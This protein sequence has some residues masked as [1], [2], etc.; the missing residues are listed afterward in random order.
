MAG[1]KV[2]QAGSADQM[3]LSRSAPP[4]GWTR[5]IASTS[6]SLGGQRLRACAGA[7]PS[8][9]ASRHSSSGSTARKLPN[10]ALAVVTL[11]YWH[12]SDSAAVAWRKDC[13]YPEVS[14]V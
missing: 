11:Q 7:V 5:R 14:L 6:R 2:A 9:P 10:A 4:L 1:N 12:P 13:H 8:T 3:Q